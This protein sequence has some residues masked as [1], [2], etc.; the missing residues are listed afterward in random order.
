[1]RILHLCECFLP[2]TGYHEA[3]LAKYQAM[4]GHEVVVL[5][6]KLDKVKNYHARHLPANAWHSC[7]RR[8]ASSGVA[9][10]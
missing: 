7:G 8:V 9:G 2:N 1:M 6:T 4:M 5:S 10:G 3:I